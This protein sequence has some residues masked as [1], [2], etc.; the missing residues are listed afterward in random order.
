MLPLQQREPLRPVFTRP[1]WSHRRN[2][3]QSS[4]GYYTPES[5][6]AR[7]KS[8]IVI[9]GVIGLCCG[10]YFYQWTAEK[11]AEQGDHTWNDQLQQN[12]ISSAKNIR[13]G[14]WWVV[15]TSSFAH[16]D[17]V[18]LCINMYCLWIFG[19]SLVHGLGVS[20][21]MGLWAVSAVSCSAAQIYWQNTQ[22]RLR[23]ETAG[24]RWERPEQFSVLGI[25]ISRERAVAIAG[26]SGSLEPHYGG[27]IGASGVLCGLTG[28]LLC[29][30]P[31]MRVLVFFLSAP[32][33]STQLIFVVG[34]MYC[35]ATGSVQLLGHAGHLGGMV[36]GVVYYYGVAR[37]WLR[38]A[39]RL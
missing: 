26:A 33:W 34:S 20:C 39:G 16:G 15:L 8:T 1:L 9:G 11:I 4:Y 5:F 2:Y 27:S 32:L 36:A 35:M 30:A 14:R 23:R 13:E 6:W 22:E 25:P 10:T 17:L 21:F 12:L 37:P 18:H 28:T 7:N 19:T 38:R 24:R 3:N 31:R 29:L